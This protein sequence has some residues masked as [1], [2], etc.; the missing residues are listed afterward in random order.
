MSDVEET[1]GEAATAALEDYRKSGGV[2]LAEIE[3]TLKPDTSPVCV[4]VKGLLWMTVPSGRTTMAESAFGVY[5]IY[6]AS[7]G[8]QAQLVNEALFA[9]HQKTWICVAQPTL[10]AAQAACQADHE[11][12]T[13]ELIN[14][15]S[16]A[17]VRAEYL[18]ELIAGAKAEYA[19]ACKAMD[20]ARMVSAYAHY[21]ALRALTEGEG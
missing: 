10:E 13:L 11:R 2:S 12:R 19:A 3:V 18:K 14:A 8:Y 16:V 15:R 4:E 9:E 6:Q 17:D 21:S 5:E 7:D 1:D 20:G